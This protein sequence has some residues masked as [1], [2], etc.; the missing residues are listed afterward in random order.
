ME[1][2]MYTDQTGRFPTKSYRGMQYIMVLVELD[3]NAILVEAR[4]GRTSGRM[5]QAYQI[6][7]N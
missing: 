5:I 1:Q 2:K 7:V 3:S 4:Q 6:L